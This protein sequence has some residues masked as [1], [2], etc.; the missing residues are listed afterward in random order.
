MI[1]EAEEH[2]GTVNV[3]FSTVEAVS[4]VWPRA[5]LRHA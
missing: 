3:L 4:N 1:F 2:N 5:V